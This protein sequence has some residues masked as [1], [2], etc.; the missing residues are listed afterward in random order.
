MIEKDTIRLL[1]ECDAGTKMAVQSLD[2]AMTKTHNE[3]LIHLLTQSKREHSQLGDHLHKLLSEKGVSDKEPPA[4]AKTM[5]H[6]QNTVKLGINGSDDPGIAEFITDGC[7]MGTKN[8][9]KYLNQYKNASGDARSICGKLI[10]LEDKL[11]SELRL[12]L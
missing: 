10:N 12:Y 1:R 8:L 5:A 7:N 11:V 3:A 9:A 4:M 6:I 2:D